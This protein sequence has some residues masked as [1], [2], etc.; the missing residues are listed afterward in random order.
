M[1]REL[2]FLFLLAALLLVPLVPAYILYRNLPSE[3]VVKGPFRGLTV[4]L[5]GAFGGYF[6]LV[7]IGWG[8]FSYLEQVRQPTTVFEYNI[9]FP[10]DSFPRDLAD[11]AVTVH[12]KKGGVGRWISHD[13]FDKRPNL[14]GIL[15]SIRDIHP[16]DT[17]YIS[18][19]YQDKEWESVLSVTVPVYQLELQPGHQR[20]AFGQ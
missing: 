18:A 13:D 15:I 16:Q 3:T 2:T 1:T 6:V 17:L 20:A 7:L 11:T 14:S 5:T 8:L 9:N 4:Q 19:R 10:G 12:V